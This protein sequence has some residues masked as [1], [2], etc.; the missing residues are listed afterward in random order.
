MA[1]HWAIED[2]LNWVASQEVSVCRG[3][4]YF[5][6]CWWSAKWGRVHSVHVDAI[7]GL[8]PHASKDERDNGG[9]SLQ[10]W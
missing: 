5:R 10:V 7:Y 8:V 9:I 6:N 4:R 3:F 2:N 1:A